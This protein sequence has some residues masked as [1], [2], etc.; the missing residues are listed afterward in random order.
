[1]GGNDRDLSDS[2]MHIGMQSK[3]SLG[4]IRSVIQTHFSS[5]RISSGFTYDSF[6]NT[7]G[8]FLATLL[9]IQSVLYLA[10]AKI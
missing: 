1:M 8:I 3:F 10:P 5:V 6:S 2:K 4:S 9:R 7:I